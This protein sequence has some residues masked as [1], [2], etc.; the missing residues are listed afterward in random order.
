VPDGSAIMSPSNRSNP[1]FTTP[2]GHF[3]WDVVAGYYLVRAEAPGCVSDAN[4]SQAY[5]ESAVLEIPP[6][7]TNL[8]L[9]LFCGEGGGNESGG[10]EDTETGTGQAPSLQIPGITGGSAAPDNDFELGSAKASRKRN[11]TAV[12]TVI[13]PGPGR[14]VARDGA[15]SG[16]KAAGKKRKPLIRKSRKNATKAGKVA[17]PIRPTKAGKRALRKKGKLAVKVRVTYTPTGGAP[18]SKSKRV[19]LKLKRAKTN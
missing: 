16:A 19:T 1:D 5:A 15:P 4:R 14:V 9:R 17:L 13:V 11:G 3:G 2:D 12:L 8:D 10:E 18:K 7:V 6:P